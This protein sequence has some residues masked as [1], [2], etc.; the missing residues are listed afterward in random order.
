MIRILTIF[1]ALVAASAAYAK[2]SKKD[3][4]PPPMPPAENYESSDV[5]M[6]D[7]LDSV[8]LPSPTTTDTYDGRDNLLIVK[9]KD[10]TYAF[11]HLSGDC[12][13]NMLMF[14]QSYTAST[15][16]GCVKTGDSLIVADSFGDKRECKITQINAWDPDATNLQDYYDQ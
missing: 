6:G 8:C 14:A 5:R 9:T 12:A 4:E 11:L 16:D 7:A 1:V 15:P 10:D 3:K 13:F 2:T